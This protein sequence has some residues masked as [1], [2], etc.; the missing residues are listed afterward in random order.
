VQAPTRATGL[1]LGQIE[2]DQT[3]RIRHTFT[4]LVAALLIAACTEATPS[5]TGVPSS[6][7]PGGEV[8]VASPVAE[9]PLGPSR[10]SLIQAAVAEG[11]IDQTTGLYYRALG[12][13]GL[14]GVPDEFLEGEPFPDH[15]VFPAIVTLIDELR[16]E[17]QARLRPFIVRPTEAES[18]FFAPPPA[19]V[20]PAMARGP[21][22]V[23]EA[24][25]TAR[26]SRWRSSEDLDSRF[27]V[28]ACADAGDDDAQLDIATLAAMI[29]EIWPDMTGDMGGPKPD[30]YGSNISADAGGDAR[31][32]FYLL[33]LG[34]AVD[35]GGLPRRIPSTAA[36]ATVPAPPFWGP[37]GDAQKSA[38]GFVLVNR[39]RLTPPDGGA[40]D[41]VGI[42]QDLIHEFFHV[43]QFAH[44]FRGTHRGEESHWFVEA[45][46]VWAEIVYDPPN[47]E[48]PH[49]WF[50]FFQNRAV[51]LEDPEEVHQ[52]AA[53][54]WPFF[55][56]QEQTKSAVL[57]AWS[58]IDPVNS[59]DF[60][61]VTDK[62]DGELGFKDNFRN[63]AVRNL[64]YETILK[65]A[66]EKTY[67]DADGN[68]WKDHP[69]TH[70][71]SG[72]VVPGEPYVASTDAP[73][74]AADYYSIEIT[75][76]ARDVT[77]SIAGVNPQAQVDGDAL[78]HFAGGGWER[79]PVTGQLE[80]C[81][82]DEDI[83]HVILVVSNHGREGSLSGEIEAS[84]R[85]TCNRE[86]HFGGTLTWEETTRFA[87]PNS[88]RTTRLTG[89]AQVVLVAR[90]EYAISL[91]AERDGGSTYR[92]DFELRDNSPGAETCET[93]EEGVLE[94]SAGVADGFFGDWS[95]GRLNVSGE[96]G[97]DLSVLLA[98]WDWCGPQMGRDVPEELR[99]R[100]IKGWP[101]CPQDGITLTAVFDGTS[102]YRIDCSYEYD[103]SSGDIVDVG[104]GRISGT[105]A[106]LDG[107]HP[108]P[109]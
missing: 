54:A 34:Q 68:F 39:D 40:A 23:G 50:P 9:A 69:P 51:G 3:G 12:A 107:P 29:S 80:F 5:P 26:C 17:D 77:I 53:Y 59:G 65:P 79:R 43:L 83:D 76:P 48:R 35:R 101:N 19:A 22:A 108:T 105:I 89:S 58:A 31:I 109:R 24:P 28:W 42:K 41:H 104:S 38:S 75:A 86:L 70:M 45:T 33:S 46:A 27:K 100:T 78:V 30:G 95:I 11:R 88:E 97:T 96:L 15:G 72:K 4:A 99:N 81:R 64:N 91:S 14:P 66:D 57:G 84:A 90:G 103:R 13:L 25:A 8:P 71:D 47:S 98:I 56:Q 73:P 74:L 44:N 102:S 2:R 52:Y 60:K 82:D 67:A 49:G 36:A 92:Y 32:D 20:V 93:H 18:A 85:D 87:T 1:A 37:N 94:T 55:M 61:G 10:A 21:V 62:I 7:Q 6:R 63:F 106:P 16:P